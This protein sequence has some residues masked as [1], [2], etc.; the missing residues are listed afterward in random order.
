MA[1]KLLQTKEL[2]RD[3]M[4]DAFKGAFPEVKEVSNFPIVV[5]NFQIPKGEKL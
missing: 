1:K 4:I 2:I 3:L 5:E